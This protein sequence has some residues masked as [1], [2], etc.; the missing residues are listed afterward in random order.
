MGRGGA[1]EKAFDLAPVS[2]ASRPI[3]GTITRKTKM[4]F[5]FKTMQKFGLVLNEFLELIYTSAQSRLVVI[6]TTI[7]T[8]IAFIFVI[9]FKFE[10]DAIIFTIFALIITYVVTFVLSLIINM[11][12]KLIHLYMHFV[13]KR[14]AS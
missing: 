9:N 8:L 5:Y 14:S 6:S 2:G 7:A 3:F 1:E 12:I 11:F 10:S 4:E 13:D